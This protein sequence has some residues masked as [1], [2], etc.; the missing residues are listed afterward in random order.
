MFFEN[1][2]KLV[3]IN[4]IDPIGGGV[5]I[6]S[7]LATLTLIIRKQCFVQAGLTRR[8]YKVHLWKYNSSRKKNSLYLVG[9]I[10]LIPLG[11]SYN[12]IHARYAHSD[13]NKAMLRSSKLDSQYFIIIRLFEL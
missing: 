12:K 6:K 4:F 10:S 5:T 1:T 9:L 2:S 13:N 3:G 8:Y 7:M 11:G